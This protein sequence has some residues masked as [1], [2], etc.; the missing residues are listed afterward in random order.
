MLR[1]RTLLGTSVFIPPTS[2]DPNCIA[3]LH[4]DG[5]INNEGYE[6]S[7]DTWTKGVN[8]AYSTSI[9]RF[10]TSSVYNTLNSQDPNPA[11]YIAKYDNSYYSYLGSSKNWTAEI[12]VYM[13][14]EFTGNQNSIFD[15]QVKSESISSGYFSIK[16]GNLSAYISHYD[17]VNYDYQNNWNYSSNP[18]SLDVWHHFAVVNYNG[19]INVYVDGVKIINLAWN[20]EPD[21]SFSEALIIGKY[22][23]FYFDEFRFSNIARYTGNFT[24][25]TTAFV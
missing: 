13:P 5:N 1:K 12:W 22:C 3:L 14:S 9:K 7:G 25:P 4:F 21:F 16:L 6:A 15:I 19:Y 24:P 2:E 18:I 23:P 11:G 20:Y 10:G 8:T 17:G